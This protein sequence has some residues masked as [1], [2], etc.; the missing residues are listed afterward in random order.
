[1]RSPKVNEVAAID[2][3]EVGPP[4]IVINSPIRPPKSNDLVMVERVLVKS[5]RKVAFGMNADSSPT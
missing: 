1:M 2:L 5:F 4:S 3:A